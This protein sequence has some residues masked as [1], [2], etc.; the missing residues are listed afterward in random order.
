MSNIS[1]PQSIL[2]M[3][4]VS[5][6]LINIPYLCFYMQLADENAFYSRPN[7]MRSISYFLCYQSSIE[8]KNSFKHPRRNPLCRNIITIKLTLNDSIKIF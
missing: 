5:Y 4:I 7:I 2:F 1:Q 8:R 6:I 3:N